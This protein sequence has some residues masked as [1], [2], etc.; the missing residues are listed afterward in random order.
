[1]PHPRRYI[2]AEN[3]GTRFK[4]IR[5]FYTPIVGIDGVPNATTNN[6]TCFRCM[7]MT[8]YLHLGAW[9]QGIKQ[10]L[11]WGIKAIVQIEVLAKARAGAGFARE[12]I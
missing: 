2:K 10:P 12:L 6:K 11:R 5:L 1:M 4:D 9:V 8:M 3:V 7:A